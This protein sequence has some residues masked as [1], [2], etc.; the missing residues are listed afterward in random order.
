LRD[1]VRAL[2][3]ERRQA[4]ETMREAAAKSA[5][6][7]AAARL[8]QADSERLAADVESARQ[9]ASSLEND[10]QSLESESARWQSVVEKLQ[11]TLEERDREIQLLKSTAPRPIAVPPAALKPAPARPSATAPKPVPVPPR[12]P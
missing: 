5:A 12:A 8:G 11:A 3:S 1:S 2:E 7:E 9:R 6:L 10:L 4:I